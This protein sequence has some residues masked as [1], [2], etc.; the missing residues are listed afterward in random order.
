MLHSA[1]GDVVVREDIDVVFRVLA[2]FGSGR[3]LENRLQRAQHESAVELRRDA[4]VVVSDRDVARD[5][6][7]HREADAD[8]VG[9]HRIDAGGFGIERDQL[10]VLQFLQPCIEL[11]GCRDEFVLAGEGPVAG[12]CGICRACGSDCSG[13]GLF[14]RR[15]ERIA[16]EV[17]R[18]VVRS[19]RLVQLFQRSLEFVARIQ[20]TQQRSVFCAWD[21]IHRCQR[22]GH[23][24]LDR[25]QRA[26]Q[27]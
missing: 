26:R 9:A 17:A 5:A 10:G 20:L 8:D 23:V 13:D 4:G 2:E 21:Q 11:R 18:T 19:L 1:Y 16:T 6:E 12:V 24:G 15:C 3:I 14:A 7:F 22:Q 27:R 25:D